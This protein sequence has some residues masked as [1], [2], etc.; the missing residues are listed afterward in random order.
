MRVDGEKVYFDEA[1]DDVRL[2]ALGLEPDET[3]PHYLEDVCV[4]G[5]RRFQD[6]SLQ[7]LVYQ[8]QSRNEDAADMAIN[9][10]RIG[11]L[12]M[13]TSDLSCRQF[14]GRTI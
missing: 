1:G 4:L 9:F 8:N 10:K 5:L 13:I 6:A 11:L 3:G 14:Q 7:H 12:Q 2:E